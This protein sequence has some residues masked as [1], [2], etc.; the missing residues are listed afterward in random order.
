[1][2]YLKVNTYNPN[3][4]HRKSIR[5]KGYDYSKAGLYF[6]TICT[7]DRKCLFGEIV[8][9]GVQNIEPLQSLNDFVITEGVE[10]FE[11]Q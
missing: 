7:A 8:P 1:M 10:N 2:T 4:H 6:I 3:I 9:V 11:P 5:L